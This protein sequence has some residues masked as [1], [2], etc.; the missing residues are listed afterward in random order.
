MSITAVREDLYDVQPL[1]GNQRELVARVPNMYAEEMERGVRLDACALKAAR[2]L[3]GDTEMRWVEVLVSYTTPVAAVVAGIEYETEER[4]S[5]TTDTH[6]AL[7]FGCQRRVRE[8]EG[9]VT[10]PQWWFD[11]L[12]EVLDN[13]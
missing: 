1:S 10:R 4:Y 5:A 8:K 7:W 2:R 12:V 13:A 9:V 11:Q 3:L 6:I